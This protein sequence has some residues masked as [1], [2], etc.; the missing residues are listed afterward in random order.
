MDEL[1]DDV[2]TMNSRFVLRDEHTGETI[3]YTLVY[4]EEEAPHDG[5]V[6][7]LSPMGMVLYGAKVGEE[8]CWMSSSGPQAA[9]VRELLYQP[10]SAGHR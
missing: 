6:S 1:S 2:I 5:K 10:E 4:P 8:V 9:T 3:I 7:V